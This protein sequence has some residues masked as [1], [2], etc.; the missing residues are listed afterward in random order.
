[1]GASLLSLRRLRTVTIIPEVPGGLALAWSF[2]SVQEMTESNPGQAWRHPLQNG[3]EGIT[4]GTRLEPPEFQVDGLVVD[5]P[6]RSLLPVPH[7]GAATLYEAIKKIRE[8]Q[9]PVTVITSWAGALSTRWPEVITGS[10]GA[11]DGG[12]IRISI[13]FVRF[14]LVSVLLAPTLIDSDMALLGIQTITAQQFG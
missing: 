9:I 10:H 13:N 1:M 8:Q 11:A 2:D 12:S 5:T 7:P 3:Q 6:I 4:D 14:R